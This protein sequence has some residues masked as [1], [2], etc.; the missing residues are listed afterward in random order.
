MDSPFKIN[1]PKGQAGAKKA[2]MHLLPPRALEEAAWAHK[3][4]ADKYGAYNWRDTGV[5][6][7]TYISA[8]MRHLNAWRDGEDDDPESGKSHLAHVICSANILLD[9]SHCDTLQ[10]DRHKQPVKIRYI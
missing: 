9:A 1:D 5:C 6:A 3:L 4:G 8:I 2:P 7:T 10:D